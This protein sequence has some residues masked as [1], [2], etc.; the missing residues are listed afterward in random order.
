MNLMTL[1][2][3]EM[4]KAWLSIVDLLT[5]AEYI[6]ITRSSFNPATGTVSQNSTI[7]RVLN[8]VQFETHRFLIRSSPS[9]WAWK[10]GTTV[11]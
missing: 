2:K 8:R 5:P 10:S 3:T 9:R 4:V 7:T 11:F 1:I 6:K